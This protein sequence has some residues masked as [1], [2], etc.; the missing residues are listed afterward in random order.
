MNGS[1]EYDGKWRDLSKI[2]D[3]LCYYSYLADCHFTQYLW[4]V[5]SAVHYKVWW[6]RNYETKVNEKYWNRQYITTFDVVKTLLKD[7]GFDSCT[8]SN[9][10]LWI[11]GARQPNHS[12]NIIGTQQSENVQPA[13]LIITPR[14]YP[15]N[16]RAWHLPSQSTSTIHL[17]W[18]CQFNLVYGQTTAQ[19]R[20]SF[21]S[22]YK[23]K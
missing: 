15:P 2:L 16:N 5:W 22:R 7:P 9:L 18:S 1:V 14:R 12:I 11:H 13:Y 23:I 17:I 20:A 8:V 3:I 21:L 4:W 6:K 19:L 10:P